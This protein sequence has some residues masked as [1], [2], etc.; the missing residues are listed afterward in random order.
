V[1]LL[2]AIPDENM[3]ILQI[4]KHRSPSGEQQSLKAFVGALNDLSLDES[5][6]SATESTP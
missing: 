4:E 6:I 1:A 5:G 3:H 2:I